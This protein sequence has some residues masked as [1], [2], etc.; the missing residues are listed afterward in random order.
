VRLSSPALRE[1]IACFFVDASA[2]ETGEFR[3]RR[4]RLSRTY[5][6]IPELN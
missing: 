3:F 2:A 5:R 6:R 1:R 4:E